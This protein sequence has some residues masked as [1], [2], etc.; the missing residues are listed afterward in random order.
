MGRKLT[1]TQKKR[2]VEDI[3][4]KTQKL[5]MAF[6]GRGASGPSLYVVSTKDLEA[7]EKLTTKW[8]KRIG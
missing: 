1:K 6:S 4:S 3:I 5:Y 7:I 2:L 8:M